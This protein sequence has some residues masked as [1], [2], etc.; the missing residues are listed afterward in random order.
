MLLALPSLHAVI[1][2][3]EINTEDLCVFSVL[4]QLGLLTEPCSTRVSALLDFYPKVQREFCNRQYL[5][6]VLVA[7]PLSM[8]IC[9]KVVFGQDCM[10]WDWCPSD[11][12]C[13]SRNAHPYHSCRVLCLLSLAAAPH[14]CGTTHNGECTMVGLWCLCC[15]LLILQWRLYIFFSQPREESCTHGYKGAPFVWPVSPLKTTNLAMIIS[16]FLFQ[17]ITSHVRAHVPTQP[18]KVDMFT[19]DSCHC[20]LVGNSSYARHSVPMGNIGEN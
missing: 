14:D 5:G 15:M 12:F 4:L 16:W 11:S 6:F 3:L 9:W 2:P 18:K 1:S 10:A 20:W 17:N 8:A 7:F 19:I 13:T